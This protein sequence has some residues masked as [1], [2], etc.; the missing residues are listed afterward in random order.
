MAEIQTCG[1]LA[2]GA[3]AALEVPMALHGSV[4]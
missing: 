1:S 3:Q 4:G 2:E